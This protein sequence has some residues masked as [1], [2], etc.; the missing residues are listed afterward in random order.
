MVDESMDA[1]QGEVA[2]LAREV[3]MELLAPAAHTA[4]H[5]GHVPQEVWTTLLDTGLAVP[6]PE[7]LGGA[8]VGESVTLMT[9]LE[10][11]AYGDA[12]ITLAAFTSGAA[13]LLIARHGGPDH[14][15]MVQ[16]VV[17]DPRARASVA[18]YE[19]GGRDATDLGTSIAVSG[20]RVRV[21]GVKVGVPFVAEADPFVVVGADAATGSL[22]AVMVPADTDGVAVHP[23]PGVLGLAAT[24]PGRVGFDAVVPSDNL[25]GSSEDAETLLN[26]VGQIRLAVAAIALGT[27]QRAIDYAADYA[28]QRMAFGQPIA[29]FQGVSFPLAEAQMRIDASRLEVAAVAASL[30][31]GDLTLAT[32]LVTGVGSATAYATGVA[33]E[34]TRTA[35]QTLG[36]H[37][38]ITEH[39]V[40]LWY[41]SASTLSVLDC[42]SLRAPFQPAL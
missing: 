7:E 21:R 26:T 40:E 29:A 27:A 32:D 30:D 20:E 9:A 37:G 23:Y 31:A 34:A 28:N 42:D 8:G 6:V 10:N 13:A 25:L 14:N 38:F 18:L 4:E 2:Q 35:V 39:P 19:S 24:T 22:R 36:G 16:R 12:G 41:R 33:A 11:L 15:D 3:G 1:T 5:Q 17:S